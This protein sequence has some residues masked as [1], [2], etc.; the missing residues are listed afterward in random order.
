[1]N[2]PQLIRRDGKFYPWG[3]AE[4]AAYADWMEARRDAMSAAMNAAQRAHH[5]DGHDF[6]DPWA[7]QRCGTGGK[8][9]FTVE[10]FIRQR[11]SPV[12]ADGNPL[13]PDTAPVE[14][15]RKQSV[16]ATPDTEPDN[17][18]AEDLP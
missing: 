8:F 7:G 4:R 6:V 18:H 14:A 17:D 9:D 16:Q 1:M 5:I 15:A 3:P 11:L 13:S 12:D 2:A 10:C